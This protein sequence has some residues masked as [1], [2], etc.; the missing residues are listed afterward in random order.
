MTKTLWKKSR[1]EPSNETKQIEYDEPVS[2]P[3][4]QVLH[5]TPLTNEDRCTLDE[6]TKK[7]KGL[8]EPYTT[9]NKNDEKIIEGLSKFQLFSD[10]NYYKSCKSVLKKLKM[11]WLLTGITEAIKYILCPLSKTD[12]MIEKGVEDFVRVFVQ[13]RNCM[14]EEDNDAPKNYVDLSPVS[15]S[16]LLWNEGDDP[17]QYTGESP[18]EATIF[19]EGFQNRGLMLNLLT[20]IYSM[21]D[22]HTWIN[23]DELTAKMGSHYIA[24]FNLTENR[25]GRYLTEDEVFEFHN[26]YN[27]ALE[28]QTVISNIQSMAISQQWLDLLDLSQTDADTDPTTPPPVIEPTRLLSE[29]EKK[30]RA[31][32]QELKQ[33]SKHIKEQIYNIVMVP[34]VIYIVYN[35]YYIFLF[36]EPFDKN[37][38]ERDKEI[39]EL[40]YTIKQEKDPQKK[41]DL[42]TK[43]RNLKTEVKD[44]DYEN[45]YVEMKDYNETLSGM[46]RFLTEYLFRPAQLVVAFIEWLKG[47]G[48]KLSYYHYGRKQYE[49]V[50]LRKDDNK[51]G[52]YLHTINNSYPHIMFFLLFVIIFVSWRLSPSFIPKT[53]RDLYFG[54]NPLILNYVFLGITGISYIFSFFSQ[55]GRSQNDD[56]NSVLNRIAEAISNPSTVFNMLSS[57][58][59]WIFKGIFAYNMVSLSVTISIIYGLANLLFG[60]YMYS[61]EPFSRIDRIN[62]FIYTRMFRISREVNE[63]KRSCIDTFNS[64]SIMLFTHLFEIITIIM[65]II[66]MSTY[67]RKI[68]N[69][70]L[71]T[72]LFMMSGIFIFALCCRIILRQMHLGSVLSPVF[73]F[74]NIKI[75][76]E[77]DVEDAINGIRS[78]AE[79]VNSLGDFMDFINGK[80]DKDDY[81]QCEEK[82]KKIETAAKNKKNDKDEEQENDILAAKMAR[83][84]GL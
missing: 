37:Q 30:Q 77:D 49:E 64:I 78:R 70:D 81:E 51:E 22:A 21:R 11:E 62:N 8:L 57:L 23:T 72:F 63:T 52:A 44:P 53:I 79:C 24:Q 34:V 76:K 4:F 35:M 67:I 58:V 50:E 82:N 26:V 29:C 43:M 56:G 18:E 65:L 10:D 36:I 54:K 55:F 20:N 13:L 41:E 47:S 33:N 6:Q 73:K 19:V 25:L 16:N 60:I 69:A 68:R 80:K 74:W 9:I 3:S 83:E 46:T 66:G 28:R 32:I 71:N 1:I 7:L 75:S 59:F 15:D 17:L 5:N 27:D 48:F 40:D 45:E 12:E 84:M 14:D 2:I 31:A 42:E 38:R 61:T 39:E